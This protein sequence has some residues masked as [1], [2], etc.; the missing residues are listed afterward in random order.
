MPHLIQI[1]KKYQEKVAIIFIEIPGKYGPSLPGMN[2]GYFHFTPKVKIPM[3]T[4]TDWKTS[5]AYQVNKTPD[6]YVID[7]E[8]IL[9]V[10]NLGHWEGQKLG[11]S[12]LDRV[13]EDLLK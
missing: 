12:E 9:R 7:K 3:A 11:D 1:H 5:A 10:A 2:E 4:D 13:I 8:G 6:Y